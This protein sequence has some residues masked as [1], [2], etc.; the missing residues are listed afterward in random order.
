MHVL[1]CIV[2]WRQ[3][4]PAALLSFLEKRFLVLTVVSE[5]RRTL[6]PLTHQ[7]EGDLRGDPIA[8]VYILV[9]VRFSMCRN[10]VCHS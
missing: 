1:Y 5:L 8:Q 6:W 2:L 7:T 3:T 4:D 10:G 9:G